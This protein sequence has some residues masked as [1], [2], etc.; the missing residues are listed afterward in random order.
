MLYLDFGRVR[1][2]W[3]PNRHG[4][5]ENLEAVDFLR[6]LNELVYGRQ[7]GA[8]T[9]GPDLT[10]LAT[11]QDAAAGSLLT[12]SEKVLIQGTWDPDGQVFVQQLDPV[13]LTVVSVVYEVQDG[14]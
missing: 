14:G 2:Q 9:V 5:P 1:G 8:F 12:G 3:T 6:R 10:N 4:G 11:S 7:S 13:P